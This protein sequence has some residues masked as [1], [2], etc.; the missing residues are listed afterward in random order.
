MYIKLEHSFHIH[1]YYTHNMDNKYII[2][3]NKNKISG[4]IKGL[5]AK[6]YRIDQKEIFNLLLP[7]KLIFI[8]T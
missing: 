4:K 8:I 2:N 6:L 7:Y 1:T 5:N 3:A